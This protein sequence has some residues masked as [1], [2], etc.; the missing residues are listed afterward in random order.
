MVS[1]VGFNAGLAAGQTVEHMH[2]HVIPRRLG[3]VVDPRGV[4]TLAGNSLGGAAGGQPAP[5]P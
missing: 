5:S 4:S 3:D 1:N 2:V